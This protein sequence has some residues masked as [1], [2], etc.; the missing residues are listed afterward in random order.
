MLILTRK[1]G[2]SILIGDNVEVRVLSVY[3]KYTKIGITAPAETTILRNE[4]VIDHENTE[5]TRNPE[6]C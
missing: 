1:R 3:G 6:S 5:K 4:L 2:E